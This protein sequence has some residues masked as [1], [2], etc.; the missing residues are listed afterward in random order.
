MEIQLVVEV[1]PDSHR[2]AVWVEPEGMYYEF[3]DAAKVVLAF[4]GADA[5]SVELTHRPDGVILWRPADT[6]VWA[7]IADGECHQIAGWSELPF[8]GLDAGGPPLS[9]PGGDLIETLFHPTPPP[10][11]SPAG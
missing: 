3:P 1:S 9:I 4:R 5:M 6:E 2:F 10:R 7:T 8:P 11:E